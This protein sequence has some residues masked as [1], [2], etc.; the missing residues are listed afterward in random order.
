MIRAVLKNP[1]FLCS[2]GATIEWIE[3]SAYLYLVPVLSRIFLPDN[4]PS[5]AA[6][7]MFC[8]FFATNLARPLGGFII[9]FICDHY[10]RKAGLMISVGLM[11]L[12]TTGIGLLP[13]Y[14]TIG[15]AA[16]MLLMAFRFM[17]GLAVSGEFTNSAMF[18][19]STAPVIL[20]WPAPGPTG[21]G[22][23]ALPQALC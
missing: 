3:Y 16:S 13:T 9:G 20:I 8:L 6:F 23:L 11:T 21:E 5:Q 1:V 19:L 15:L 12:A 10:G 14:E 17:Q 2:T 18:I 7:I 4:N 22:I